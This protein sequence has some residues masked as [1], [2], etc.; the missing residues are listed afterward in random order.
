MAMIEALRARCLLMESGNL[1]LDAPT[2]SA[3]IRYRGID[4]AGCEIDFS[5][6]APENGA[7]ARLLKASLAR[8]DGTPAW[9]FDI[10]D[11]IYIHMEYEIVEDTNGPAVPNFHFTDAGGQYLCV[12]NM[13]GVAHGRPGRYRVC[14]AVPGHLFNNGQICVGL[15]LTSYTEADHHVHFYEQGAFVINVAEDSLSNPE[16]YGYGGVVP[17]GF[18]PFFTW[19]GGVVDG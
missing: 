5:R 4:A 10:N 6:N 18:R 8:E 1:V 3:I 17:G 11:P 15:A 7:K 13:P 16:R 14:C 19:S 9:E 12:G 2:A